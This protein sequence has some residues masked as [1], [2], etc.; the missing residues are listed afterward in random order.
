MKVYSDLYTFPTYASSL[1]SWENIAPNLRRASRGE[2]LIQQYAE[3]MFG[4][5][6]DR[7]DVEMV[8]SD[9]ISDMLH[10]IKFYHHEVAT[11][12]V[13]ARAERT[14]AGDS[15]DGPYEEAS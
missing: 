11:H 4:S 9:L 1:E 6:V 7:K 5:D 12:A 15:E 13:V 3:A 10:A 2:W 8:A 14:F